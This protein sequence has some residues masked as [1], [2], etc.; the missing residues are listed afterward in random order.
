ME[1][2]DEGDE[3]RGARARRRRYSQCEAFCRTRRRCM[4]E[5]ELGDRGS[6]MSAQ[7]G[8]T[9]DWLPRLRE[10]GLAWVRTIHPLHLILSQRPS[11]TTLDPPGAPCCRRML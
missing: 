11:V 1:R 4:V 9:R 3:G 5:R 6:D 2:G 10:W 8:C 7:T